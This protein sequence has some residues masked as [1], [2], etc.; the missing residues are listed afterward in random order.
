MPF[1]LHTL[2]LS[3]TFL[4]LPISLSHFLAA[5][6]LPL[7]SNGQT[8]FRSPNDRSHVRYSSL[9]F[10]F[11][12]F[13][14]G[15]RWLRQR[16]PIRNCESRLSSHSKHN[17]EGYSYGIVLQCVR[18]SQPVVLNEEAFS[19]HDYVF[20][21]FHQFSHNF[22]LQFDGGKNNN[23]KYIKIKYIC[24]RNWNGCPSPKKFPLDTKAMWIPA[25]SLLIPIPTFMFMLMMPFDCRFVVPQG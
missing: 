18:I 21:T 4:C 2:C 1:R 9:W 25:F 5:L 23:R 12:L 7:F 16:Q 3:L 8:S 20:L 22:P 10:Y 6:F 13:R 24:S 11:P 17:F 15:Y 19:L 14:N